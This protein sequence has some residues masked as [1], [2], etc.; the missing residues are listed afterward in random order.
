VPVSPA[1]VLSACQQVDAAVRCDQR[2]AHTSAFRVVVD[3]EVAYSA[4]YRGPA[5]AEVFSVTKTVLATVAGVAARLGRLPPLDDAVDPHVRAACGVDLSTTPSAGQ[6]WRQLLTMTRGSQVDGPYEIDEVTAL[7]SGWV[8]RIAE[9]P[10]LEPP[11][12]TFRYDN[13]AAHL[14]AAALTG[15]LGEEVGAVAERELFRPLGIVGAQWTRDPDGI[16]CGAGFL[17]LA[18]DHLA[19]L[20]QLWLDRG[21]WQVRQLADPA[22]LAAM[23]R[24]QSAGGP[25]ED[26]PYG[27]LTWVA[28]DHFFAGGWAGQHVVVVPAARAVVVVTGDPRFR[29][30]PPPT[31]ELPPD[32]RPALELVRTHLLPVLRAG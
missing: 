25:P 32:W 23:V 20:G 13:G 26:C 18:T 14:L 3:G 17:R 4:R 9:A 10:R 24:P 6:T 5:V 2:Y 31:D 19:A 27:F 8:R 11:G 15:A 12:R 21:R 28:A 16:A 1:A 29:L 30:G 22:F 7:P